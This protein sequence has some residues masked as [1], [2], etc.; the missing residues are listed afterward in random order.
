[1]LGCR[2]EFCAKGIRQP[3]CDLNHGWLREITEM[4]LTSA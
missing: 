2:I 1:M 3:R 4:S